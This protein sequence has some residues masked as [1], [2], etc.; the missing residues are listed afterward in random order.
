M[1]GRRARAQFPRMAA[2]LLVAGAAALSTSTGGATASAAS[3]PCGTLEA[4]TLPS[5]RHVIVIM[6]ENLSYRAFTASTQAGYLH[7][8]ATAC[9]SEADMHNATHPSQPNYMAATSG[10]VSGVGVHTANDN[11]FH[12]AQ[13]AGDSWRV[14][15]E[16][17]PKPCSGAASGAPTYKT[18]H[19]PAFWYTDLRTPDACATDDVPASP[20][21]AQAI[22]SDS[23]PT[24]S[25][26]APDLCDDMHWS[27]ACPY[28]SSQRVAKGDAWLSAL[29]PTI[30]A[31]PSYQAGQTLVVV[32][33]DEG[34][35]ASTPDVDCT[36]PAYFAGHA[37]CQIATIVVSPY[38]RPGAVDASDQNLYSLLGTVEDILGYPRIGHAVGQPSMRA[39]L[40]F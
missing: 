27:S 20:A 11:L 35:G 10:L 9:G 17:M 23:L 7:G 30:T 34:N 40:G 31:M 38:I 16:T 12:Q 33:F 18:G 32:T 37:D 21:L 24:F 39:G 15:A 4:T 13:V 29:L 8:L 36:D 26:V 19:N 3:G 6:D 14:Y 2:A 22:S 28:P 5:Y 25:W 1:G